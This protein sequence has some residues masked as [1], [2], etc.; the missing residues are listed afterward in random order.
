MKKIFMILFS[1]S[2]LIAIGC[3]NADVTN[4]RSPGNQVEYTYADLQSTDGIQAP[5]VLVQEDPVVQVPSEDPELIFDLTTL[6]SDKWIYVILILLGVIKIIV[7]LTP[8]EK[9]NKIFA[10]IDAF[11]DW[12]IPNRRKGGGTF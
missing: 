8:T 7:N 3:S 10:P 5:V 1:L 9:D 4:D 2:L 11:F 6:L 12:I